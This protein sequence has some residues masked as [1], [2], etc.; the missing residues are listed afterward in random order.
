MPGGDF[1]K[2]T[3]NSTII[4]R[5]SLVGCCPYLKHTLNGFGKIGLRL[6]GQEL[7]GAFSLQF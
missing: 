1:T 5:E 7:N 3:M 2:D 4:P 6:L